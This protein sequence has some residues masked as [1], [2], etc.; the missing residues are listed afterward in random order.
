[1]SNERDHE[2]H[3]DRDSAPPLRFGT[4]TGAGIGALRLALLFGSAVIALALI[5]VPMLAGRG[6]LVRGDASGLDMMSTGSIRHDTSYTIRR[7]VLQ[8]APDAVCLIRSDGR[9]SGRC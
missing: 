2:S 1:M 8:P 7:S 6:P 5:A 4:A 9:Q 3:W